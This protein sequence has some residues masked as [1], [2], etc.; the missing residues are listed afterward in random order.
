MSKSGEE[1]KAPP[2]ETK[3]NTERK[4]GKKKKNPTEFRREKAKVDLIKILRKNFGIVSDACEKVGVSRTT[5]YAWIQDDP[6]FAEEYHDI[7]E[8]VLDFGEAALYR[9]VKEGNTSLIRFFLENKGRSRGYGWNNSNERGGAPTIV[10][11]ISNIE[12]DY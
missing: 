6:K 5:F 4:T 1:K 11:K 9:G 7:Q 2:K 12:A 10:V 8:K 3:L